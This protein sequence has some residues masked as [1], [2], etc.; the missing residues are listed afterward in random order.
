MWPFTAVFLVLPTEKK[1]LFILPKGEYM[2][3][4]EVETVP[5]LT[6]RSPAAAAYTLHDSAYLDQPTLNVS[7]GEHETSFRFDTRDLVW[8]DL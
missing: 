5:G 7:S 2:D 4:E 1:T 8:I 3:E 6:N